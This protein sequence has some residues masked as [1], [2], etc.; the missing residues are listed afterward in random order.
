MFLNLIIT[1]D[2]TC[3][4]LYD[5]QQIRQR[6]NWKTPLSP[7]QQKQVKRQGSTWTDQ[8]EI[9]PEGATLNKTATWV[10]KYKEFYL[11]LQRPCT[12]LSP[13]P[14]GNGHTFHINLKSH[15]AFFFS[16][17][18]W[19]QSYVGVDFILPKSSW[20]P[21]EKPYGTFQITPLSGPSNNYTHVDNS[22]QRPTTSILSED[23][24]L[25]KSTDSS[26]CLSFRRESQNLMTV[27]VYC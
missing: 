14:R 12:Q 23:V 7:R 11:F 19:E 9:I 3:C 8:V 1:G 25:F 17:L 13:S 4:F 20:L 15:Y 27:V 22:E 2:K 16:L 26:G 5:T 6:A 21:Q 24:L 18:A 10:L